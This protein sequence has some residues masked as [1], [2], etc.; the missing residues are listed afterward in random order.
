MSDSGECVSRET[1]L[2]ERHDRYC[3]VTWGS[4]RERL[5]E[6]VHP[7]APNTRAKKSLPP[8]A[9]AANDL[10]GSEDDHRGSTEHDRR[11]Q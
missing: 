6:N 1:V 10:G 5:T 8:S 7:G 3:G 4:R 9:G 2:H 11:K